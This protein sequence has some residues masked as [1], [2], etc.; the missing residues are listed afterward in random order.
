VLA[1][2]VLLLFGG[3]VHGIRAPRSRVGPELAQ[4]VARLDRVATKIGD[5]VGVSLERDAKSSAR[6]GIRGG[7]LRRYTNRRNGKVVTLLIV[8]GLPGPLSVHTPD[9]CYTSAGYELVGVR[10]R[11]GL[12]ASA[13]QLADEFWKI[14]MREVGTTAPEL[15]DVHYAWSATGEWRAP[16]RDPRFEFASYP[17]LYKLYVL[18]RHL[19]SDDYQAEEP[20]AEFLRDLTPALKESLFRS[21]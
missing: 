12:P 8:T 4:A 19:S 15:L 18:H 20:G 6:V 21:S 11:F 14:R 13:G 9:V 1:A 10:M 3:A 7:L 5:W 17:F 16:V 2:T